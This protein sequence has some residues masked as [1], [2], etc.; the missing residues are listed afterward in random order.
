VLRGGI[1]LR[2]ALILVISLASI[3]I[4]HQTLVLGETS[5]G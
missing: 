4:S 3:S 2:I 5:I 1:P